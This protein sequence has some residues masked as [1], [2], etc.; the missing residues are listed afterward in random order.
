ME[1]EL[2][3]YDGALE[4]LGGDS[5]FLAELLGEMI[6]QIDEQFDMLKEA[7]KNLDYKSLHQ[8][9]HGL[10]GASANL[11]IT[12]LFHLFQ[13]LEEQGNSQ[14]LNDADSILTKIESSNKELR[15]FVDNL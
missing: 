1:I 4:R 5:E 10:K 3:N 7:V 9:A 13:E 6:V 12:R 2:I 8:T 11:D 14:S 15:T